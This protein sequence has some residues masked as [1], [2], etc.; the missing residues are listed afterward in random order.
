MWKEHTDDNILIIK[1]YACNICV[2]KIMYATIIFT[3]LLV[4]KSTDLFIVL[5]V[6]RIN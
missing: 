3:M 4:L 6:S 1:M 5:Q 2:I